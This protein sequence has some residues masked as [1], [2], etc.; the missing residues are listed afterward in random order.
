MT[1]IPDGFKKGKWDRQFEFYIEI[2]RNVPVT[3]PEN[4]RKPMYTDTMTVYITICYNW[5]VFDLRSPFRSKP[6]REN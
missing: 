6:K 4:L 3:N 2:V 5:F 1:V